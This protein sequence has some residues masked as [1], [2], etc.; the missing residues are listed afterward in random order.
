LQLFLN[1][2]RQVVWAGITGSE[3]GNSLT[4]VL[5][6]A[7]NPSGRLPYMIAKSPLDYPAQL[8]TGG[9][10]GEI[11]SIPYTEGRVLLAS[12]KDEVVLM[13]D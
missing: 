7:W 1:T 5:Y 13:S 2:P 8:V 6:G 12:M 10:A 4:D 11:L 9:E 3:V